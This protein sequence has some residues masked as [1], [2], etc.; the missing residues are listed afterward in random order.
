MR[1]KYE[2]VVAYS[3]LNMTERATN[4]VSWPYTG[5]TI[6]DEM[7]CICVA[8]E[9]FVCGECYDIHLDETQLLTRYAPKR[10]IESA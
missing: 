3:C 10:F 9:G 2:L 4:K 6:Y 1:P 7:G 5:I 8:L